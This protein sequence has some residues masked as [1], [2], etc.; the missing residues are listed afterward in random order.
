MC[1]CMIIKQHTHLH[2]FMACVKL[3]FDSTIRNHSTNTVYT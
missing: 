2:T 3:E 1:M